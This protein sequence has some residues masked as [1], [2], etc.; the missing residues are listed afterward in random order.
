MTDEAPVP[1]DS[2]GSLFDFSAWLYPR[3]W[4]GF[5]LVWAVTLLPGDL[6]MIAVNLV[7]GSADAAHPQGR[8]LII[9]AARILVLVPAV[10]L[11]GWVCIA[12]GDAVLRGGECSLLGASG[13]VLS[14]LP[15]QIWTVAHLA[16]RSL[17]FS[18]LAGVAAG[19]TFQNSPR[20]AV[21]LVVLIAVP[22]AYC[23]MHWMLAP[24][25]TL[26]E[27]LSGGA[28]LRR[29]WEL[30]GVRFWRFAFQ[31]IVYYAAALVPAAVIGALAAKLLPASSAGLLG[32]AVN[33]L[34]ITPFSVGLFLA[35][36]RREAARG[37]AAAAETP[38]S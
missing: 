26:L 34:L 28:A 35:L 31:F 19:F 17:P 29:S 12:M 23:V 4:A 1:N 2:L 14:R 22:A 16:I 36:Y 15:A 27:G 10:I 9:A 6:V 38:P 30:S 24:I 13:R 5:A 33:G 18:L 32:N 21:A 11:H 20:T 7:F 25:V 3:V 8:T 37:A